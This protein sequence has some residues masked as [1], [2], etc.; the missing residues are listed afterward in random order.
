MLLLALGSVAGAQQEPIAP[1][2]ALRHLRALTDDVARAGDE[3]LVAAMRSLLVA[4][5][6]D[7]AALAKLE[8]SWRKALEEKPL[9]PAERDKLVRKLREEARS[10]ARGLPALDEA[11]RPALARAIL[12]LD[13]QDAAA[14][15]ALGNAQDEHGA[16][17]TPERA[18]WKLG[19]ARASA[20]MAEARRLPLAIERRESGNPALVELY[21]HANQVGTRSIDVHSTIAPE[22]LERVLSQALRACAFSYGLLSGEVRLPPQLRP[23]DF[24]LLETNA[25]YRRALDEALEAGGIGPA[26]QQ[27]AL[28]LDL[29]SFIDR[30]GWRTVR[31]GAEANHS[32]LILSDLDGDW[33]GIHAQ[34]C[35]Q[36]GHANWIALNFLG[37]SIPGVAWIESRGGSGTGTVAKREE[38]FYRQSLVR[39]ARRSLYGCRA[40][41]V[42]Q[43]RA[44][45][46]PPWS[47]AM[48]D[49]QGKIVDEDLFKTTLVCQMLQEEGRLW[50]LLEATRRQPAS[51]MST[52]LGEPLADVEARW[53][54]WLLPEGTG[55]V[56]RL[57]GAPVDGAD[58]PRA[59]AALAAVNRARSA[60]LAGQQPE[61]ESVELDPELGHAAALHAAF[62]A[63]N[64]DLKSKWPDVHEEYV[65]REGSSPEGTLAGLRSVI[66]FER[67]PE[68]AVEGWLGT[69]YHRLPLLHPG[70]FGI[71]Y[72]EH[73][74]V[75]V[76]DTGSLVLD[77]WKDHVVLWPVPDARNVPRAFELEIP[78]PLP[79]VDLTGAG[80]PVTVQLFFRE[81]GDSFELAMELFEGGEDSKNAVPCWFLTPE[82]PR[83]PDLAP[84]NAWCLIA[85][86]KLKT[87]TRYTVRARWREQT[88]T[89]SFT[90]GS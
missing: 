6:D 61:I 45:K 2:A 70:L 52:M 10:L 25:D 59:L 15:T 9:E 14:Q 71:G 68:E 46:D 55:I 64:P 82:A 1:A 88:R 24:V 86:K 75:I 4:L 31:F 50:P 34:P 28:E 32:A 89:W 51:K 74:D 20:L 11:S 85:E 54:R 43:V 73:G 36:A 79:G 53:E 23:R 62:L 29:G 33:I 7:E 26:D 87:G 18:S 69:F 30:R 19:A 57:A 67:T 83:F 60:A 47:Q 38:D 77:P 84:E 21:G 35:L 42:R 49:H 8:P 66:S 13:A 81:P 90:T 41:M 5:G 72:G 44:G 40:W 39:C 27:R 16:W 22:R 76:L 63:R 12:V 48:V 17:M 80:Y 78:N 58:D 65:D 37:T 3:E 56:Q